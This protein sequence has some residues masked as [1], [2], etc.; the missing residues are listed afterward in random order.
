MFAGK[1]PEDMNRYVAG[2]GG[3]IGALLLYATNRS[4]LGRDWSETIRNTVIGL[5][6][7]VWLDEPQVGTRELTCATMERTSPNAEDV[8]TDRLVLCF[9]FGG[10]GDRYASII[11]QGKHEKVHSLMKIRVGSS[12][13]GVQSVFVSID[14]VGE[15]C[16]VVTMRLD[17]FLEMANAIIMTSGKL[18]VSDLLAADLLLARMAKVVLSTQ[19]EQR[20]SDN[21]SGI[22]RDAPA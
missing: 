12:M 18:P 7:Y 6:V 5:N 20:S 11:Y 2:I 4:R 8:P 13:H 17:T 21:E 22:G 9:P 19:T 16:T 15:S 10:P 1:V 3:A 14:S